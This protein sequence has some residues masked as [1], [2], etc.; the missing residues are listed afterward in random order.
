MPHPSRPSHSVNHQRPRSPPSHDSPSPL[1]TTSG[2]ASD[3]TATSSPGL[4]LSPNTSFSVSPLSSRLHHGEGEPG[5]QESSTPELLRRMSDLEDSD[6]GL[7]TV[8]RMLENDQTTGGR[9]RRR[10][11]AATYHGKHDREQRASGNAENARGPHPLHGAST[12]VGNLNTPYSVDEGDQTRPSLGFVQAS[13][14]LDLGERGGPAQEQ[15]DPN[16]TPRDSPNPMSTRSTDSSPQ[17]HSTKSHKPQT[18]H[19]NHAA[20]IKQSQSSPTSSHDSHVTIDFDE[21]GLPFLVS[22]LSG[23]VRL[24]GLGRDRAGTGAQERQNK[25]EDSATYP[26][27]I[28]GQASPESNDDAK[29]ATRE[30]SVRDF[31][32]DQAQTTNMRDP[33]TLGGIEEDGV[34]RDGPAGGKDVPS[35]NSRAQ[36]LSKSPTNSN[37]DI[38]HLDQPTLTARFEYVLT[39]DGHHVVNGREGVL[40]RC[41]D[42]PISTPGAIQGFG[43][44]MVLEEDVENGNLEVRQVSEN[45]TQILGLSPRYLFQLDCFTRLLTDEQEDLFR[46]MLEYLPD[47]SNAQPGNAINEA[48]QRLE[49]LGPLVFRLSGSGEPGSGRALQED[50]TPSSST[51]GDRRE[52]TCWV[53]AHIPQNKDWSKV[54]EQGE[55]VPPP[56]LIILEFELETDMY[57]PPYPSPGPTPS[58]T[59]QPSTVTPES[60][61]ANATGSAPSTTTASTSSSDV[62]ASDFTTPARPPASTQTSFTTSKTGL[63]SESSK[64]YGNDA[65]LDKVLESTTNRAKPLQ[66]L[67]RMRGQLPDQGGSGRRKPRKT[68]PRATGEFGAIDTLAVM[69]EINDQLG[70]ATDLETFLDVTVGLVQGVSRFHRVMIYQ[71]DES[72]HGV[73][74]SELAD[75]DHTKD[76]YKGLKFPAADIPPQARELYKINKVRTLYDRKLTTARMVLRYREDLEYPLDMTHCYLRAMS[77]IHLQYLANMGARSSM[78]VSIMAFGQLWGL[79]AC[80]SFG[81]SGMRVSFPFRQML[82]VLSDSISKNIERLSYAQRLSARKIISAVPSMNHP[83][84]YIVS[85]A[86]DLLH[87]FKADA[88]LLV[89]GDGCKPLGQRQQGPAMMAIAEYLRVKKLNSVKAS[90]SLVQD[91]PDLSLPK[92]PETIAGLLYVPLSFTAGQDFIVMLRKGQINEVQW[93]GKPF[94]S[95]DASREAILEP[96]QSFNKWTE[97]VAGTTRAWSDD[98]LESAGILALIYGKFIQV[99]R[100]KQASMAS[101]QLTAILLSNTSHAVRTPLSQ[102]INTLEL[103]LS[104]NLDPET[105]K[106]LKDSHQASKSLLFHVHDLLDLTRIETGNETAFKDPF[107]L[108]QS[109][110]EAIRLYETETTRRGIEFRVKTSDDLPQSVIGDSMKIR[111]VIANLVANSVKFTSKGFIEVY[112][113]VLPQAAVSCDDGAQDRSVN[114]E[115]VISDSGCGIANEKLQAMFLALEGVGESS[116][117]SG[118]GLGLAVVARIVEQLQGQLRAESEEGTGTRFLFSLSM[119]VHDPTLS[120]S[121]R[122]RESRSTL[123]N[124]SNGQ[125]SSS[126]KSQAALRFDKSR[127]PD[128]ESLVQDLQS[129]HLSAASENDERLK[130]A[131]NRMSQPGTVPVVDSSFPLKPTKL[132]A[133]AETSAE[134]AL[135]EQRSAPKKSS[136]SHEKPFAHENAP[137]TAR[138]PDID[139]DPS[140]S[141]TQVPEARQLR[142]MVVEDDPI[143]SQILQRRLK[144]EKHSVVAVTNGQEAVDFLESERNIDAILM[145]IQMPIMDGRTA[146]REIRQLEI[147]NKPPPDTASLLIDARV[148]IFAVS[149]SLYESDRT[150]LSENFDGWFLKPLNFSRI[151]TILAGLQ[152]PAKRLEEVY[153]QGHWE[154]GGYFRGPASSPS[155]PT[156]T[157]PASSDQ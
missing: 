134:S 80:H 156:T 1:S 129:S 110:S 74:V 43:A 15:R 83:T 139:S 143:N 36:S 106:M 48:R 145:D 50:F 142:V 6:L 120:K 51:Q 77:P 3:H 14:G 68:R 75:Q 89:I 42:E 31:V 16:S 54:D 45:S 85:N 131:G 5:S 104:G 19:E 62:T 39:E 38:E 94:K 30:N 69:G 47:P 124:A 133:D 11:G 64:V 144:M 63:H 65:D 117:D 154:A 97:Q 20:K 105:R 53:A 125:H 103:A 100:E 112:C 55:P 70:A 82:R 86:D 151:R 122:R 152:D 59:P 155:T 108:R 96:R 22:D 27:A 118:V 140:S 67:E 73:V 111:T 78:S 98:Q 149:A 44:L 95:P 88:G 115:I 119:V 56:N 135:S 102:I 114:I 123:K 60:V 93:G 52:W 57:N 79:I 23:I 81:Q 132:S 7:H 34:G 18:G 41:E 136:V 76:F 128:I 141:Q 157:S 146:A 37:P 2:L 61:G 147:R 148:P 9:T 99:W 153:K 13:E 126:A 90:S 150:N 10:P 21:S 116:Q 66:S 46:D 137:S 49:G 113:G 58:T 8:T 12:M 32:D 17:S 91:Y 29:H 109:I 92:S 101:S 127:V 130:A 138:V 72:M 121:S 107:N 40:K 84:G 28:R 33:N 24:G 87:I 25:T 35:T 71:F 4:S 26:F